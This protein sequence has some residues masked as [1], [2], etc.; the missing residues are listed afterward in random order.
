[1]LD[2]GI[3]ASINSDDPAYFGGYIADNFSACATALNLTK[4][5]VVLSARN[6]FIGSFLDS[7]TKAAYLQKLNIYCDNN[8]VELG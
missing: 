5:E 7:N 6:S 1:M 2:C 3:I 8:K 4:T